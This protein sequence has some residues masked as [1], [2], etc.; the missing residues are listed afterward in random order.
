M[1]RYLRNVLVGSV[2]E[3]LTLIRDQLVLEGW[4]I[5]SGNVDNLPMLIAGK[6]V[7]SVRPYLKFSSTAATNIRV[8]GDALGN[9]VNLS[10]S[11]EWAIG[12]GHR[13]WMANDDE[14]FCLYI[15]PSS[16]NGIIHHGGALERI[17]PSDGWAWA[18]GQVTSSASSGTLQIAQGWNITTK[19]VS[20]TTNHGISSNIFTGNVANSVVLINP[21]LGTPI[22]APYIKFTATEFRGAVKFAVSGLAGLNAGTEYEQRDPVT[23]DLL[24]VYVGDSLAAFEV[25]SA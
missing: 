19:W 25:F 15:K 8:N 23:N 6:D 16:G 4:E 3:A 1:P 17:L 2:V 24:K 13:L 21:V 11:R 5:I 18:V 22:V 20:S 12:S 14:S 7:S 9:D 10:L